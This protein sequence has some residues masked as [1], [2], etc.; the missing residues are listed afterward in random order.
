MSSKT[1]VKLRA[2]LE[3][4]P[5]EINSYLSFDWND[6]DVEKMSPNELNN[7]LRDVERLADLAS[8][9]NL[10]EGVNK[11]I[12]ACS[13]LIVD[14]LRKRSRRAIKG[15]YVIIDPEATEGRDIFQVTEA[16]IQGGVSIIQYRDKKSDRSEFL[17]NAFSL[18]NLCDRSSV[19]F[20]INDAADVARIVNSS[21]LHVGQSDLDVRSA[22]K[23]L[24]SSQCVGTSNDGWKE[25]AI[26]EENGA[27]YLAVGAVYATSTMGKSS[28][29]PVGGE[30]LIEVKNKSKIPVVAIGGINK[31]NLSAVR[32]TGVDAACIVSSITHATDPEK[33]SKDLVHIWENA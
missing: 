26:S 13:D 24:F 33:S 4:F 16:V 25:S 10:Q 19:S 6:V 30:T 18:K 32:S 20:V 7:M 8:L 14:E 1:L 12:I 15:I 22:R 9:V 29:V 2:I 31:S 11:E 5:D 3:I 27:D 23:V 21:F 28:R 17:H